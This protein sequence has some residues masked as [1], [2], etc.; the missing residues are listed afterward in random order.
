MHPAGAQ[1]IIII[2]F[3]DLMWGQVMLLAFFVDYLKPLLG[4]FSIAVGHV[5]LLLVVPAVRG[6]HCL[7][8]AHLIR[9]NI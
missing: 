6:C 7:G 1:L 9:N 2:K 4:S 3:C 5:A 8:G